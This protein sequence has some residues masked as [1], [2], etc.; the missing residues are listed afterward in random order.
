MPEE[1]PSTV[2]EII[3]RERKAFTVNLIMHEEMHFI[4]VLWLTLVSSA[5]RNQRQKDDC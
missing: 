5:L 3:T 1:K 2:P 4:Q